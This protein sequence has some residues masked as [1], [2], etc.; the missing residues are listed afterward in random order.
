V[1]YLSGLLPSKYSSSVMGDGVIGLIP[2]VNS[3][4][5]TI[6]RILID[7]KTE[8]GGIALRNMTDD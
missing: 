6:S 2:S 1:D 7:L 3:D 4:K 8:V 5:S